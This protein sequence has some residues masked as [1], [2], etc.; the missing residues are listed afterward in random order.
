MIIDILVILWFLCLFILCGIDK[1]NDKVRKISLILL[2]F[3]FVIRICFFKKQIED[4]RLL[5]FEC[6]FLVTSII[7]PLYFR[8]NS[9]KIWKDE[10]RYVNG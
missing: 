2:V 10:A 7:P 8:F 5:W 4:E 9:R 3:L 6:L 1:Y